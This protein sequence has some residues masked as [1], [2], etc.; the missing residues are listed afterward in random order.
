MTLFFDPGLRPGPRL[1]RLRRPHAPR[2]S[3]AGALRAPLLAVVVVATL[4][5]G[6]QTTQGAQTTQAPQQPRPRREVTPEQRAK[7]EAA[8]PAE[9]VAKPK[10]PRKLLVFDRQ[11]IYNGKPYGG[12][13]SIPHAN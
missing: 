4:S 3:L 1:G 11:G 13:G 7:I 8:L 10:K 5:A 9:A 12:H 6:G 2:R